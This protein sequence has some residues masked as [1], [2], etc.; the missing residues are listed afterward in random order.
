MT[1][2]SPYNYSAFKTYTTILFKELSL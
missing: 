1:P 2:M